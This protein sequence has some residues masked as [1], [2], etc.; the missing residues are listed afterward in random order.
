MPSS[1]RVEGETAR[2]RH[3]RRDRC[4][5]AA[6][7]TSAGRAR[8]REALAGAER[9]AR[10]ARRPDRRRDRAQ[11]LRRALRL[12]NAV[13]SRREGRGAPDRGLARRVRRGRGRDPRRQRRDPRAQGE[14][15][16][17]R[18]RARAASSARCKANP[19]R[20]MEVRIDL[21]ADA[22]S[23]ADLPRQLH[24]ARRA[25]GA[26][27]RCAARYRHARA[28]ARARTGPPRRDRAADRRGLERRR[29]VGLDRAHRQGRQRAGAA[30]ADR[31]LCRAAV[32]RR[33]EGSRLVPDRV[34][35]AALPAT[36]AYAE[37]PRRT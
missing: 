23:R 13:R 16:R 5:P 26:A 6:C 27:L 37:R 29:A 24:G 17:A 34:R 36:L 20:K 31:A 10:G 25:L 12:G 11:A 3:H 30:A 1:L 2:A 28:Q 33:R 4:A 32:A 8:A 14:A 15:A 9:R 21:A 22:G 7:R 18:R 35:C 19:P